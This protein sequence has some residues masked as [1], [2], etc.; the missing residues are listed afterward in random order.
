MFEEIKRV[1]LEMNKNVEDFEKI[2]KKLNLGSSPS[3][4]SSKMLDK[5]NFHSNRSLKK[6]PLCP[7]QLKKKNVN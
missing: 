4:G 7:P 1:I 5:P 6:N 3:F 2:G